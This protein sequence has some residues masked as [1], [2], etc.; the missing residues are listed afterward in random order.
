MIVTYGFKLDGDF[1]NFDG[2]SVLFFLKFGGSDSGVFCKV[3]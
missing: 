2:K 1:S 3:L